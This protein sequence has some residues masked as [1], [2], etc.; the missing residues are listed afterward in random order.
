MTSLPAAAIGA[1]TGK[2][3]VAAVAAVAGGAAV[4]APGVAG[5]GGV[6]CVRWLR[7]HRLSV[8][9]RPRMTAAAAAMTMFRGR[10]RPGGFGESTGVRWA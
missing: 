10:L 3:G 9:T 4:E 5:P 6:E 2:I 1:G 8:S 7:G